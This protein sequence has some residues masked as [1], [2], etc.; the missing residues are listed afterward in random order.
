MFIGAH[1]EP[2]ESTLRPPY[3][4]DVILYP[5]INLPSMP[6]IFKWLLP[7][8]RFRMKPLLHNII[9]TTRVFFSLRYFSPFTWDKSAE[10]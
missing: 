10:A 1:S 3:F 6:K 5:N 7:A 9:L 8:N 4:F 2:E